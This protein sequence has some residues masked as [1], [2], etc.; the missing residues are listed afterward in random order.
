MRILA[1]LICV[2]LMTSCHK[3][4]LKAVKVLKLFDGDSFLV[5][6]YPCLA[7]ESFQVR[8]L[9]IDAPEGS[10][11]P[12]GDKAKAQLDSLINKDKV[13]F[14][15]YDLQKIDKYQRHLSFAFADD[16]RKTLI[17][18]EMIKSGYAVLYAFDKDLKYLERLQDA[19]MH[20]KSSNLGIWD[21]MNGLKI[22]PSKFRSKKKKS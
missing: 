3:S 10:Q 18:E 7:C 4:E 16:E 19:E 6:D 20:A 11:K 13:I 15:E 12:W 9:G 8:M 17:N 21:T 14:L 1:A 2:L 22:S 5:Q